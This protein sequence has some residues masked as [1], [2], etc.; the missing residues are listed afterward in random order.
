MEMDGTVTV[1]RAGRTFEVL[2]QNSIDEQVAAVL[3]VA[4]DTLSLR[5]YKAL[6]AIRG[7]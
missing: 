5:T 4:G 2:A 6:Y 3:A 1:L 7:N